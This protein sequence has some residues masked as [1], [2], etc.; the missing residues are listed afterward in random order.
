VKFQAEF[1]AH[2]ELTRTIRQK[3]EELERAK[4]RELFESA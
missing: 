4:A 3:K 1:E 2:D